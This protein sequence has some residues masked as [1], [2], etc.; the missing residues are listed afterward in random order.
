MIIENWRVIVCE[1][2]VDGVD[3]PTGV[4]VIGDAQNH[5]TPLVLECFHLWVKDE[6]Y[7]ASTRI[8]VI[9]FGQSSRPWME[10]LHLSGL[11]VINYMASV[12]NLIDDIG[13]LKEI[14]Q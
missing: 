4:M 9:R 2:N 3:I 1:T 14:V 11:T 5:E 12:M 6:S 8:G 13:A 10:S 7:H